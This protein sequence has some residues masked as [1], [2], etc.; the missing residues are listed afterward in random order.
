VISC[1]FDQKECG[2][3]DFVSFQHEQYGSCHTF[4]AHQMKRRI[5]SNIGKNLA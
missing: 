5:T 1:E 2:R 3:E 4:N